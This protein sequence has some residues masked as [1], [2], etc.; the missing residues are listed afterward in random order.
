MDTHEYIYI[1]TYTCIGICREMCICKHT[2][3]CTCICLPI[4]NYMYISAFMLGV[5]GLGVDPNGKP[6]VKGAVWTTAGQNP[7]RAPA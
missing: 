7:A 4:Y 1:H 3:I 5:A 6:K 2:Y